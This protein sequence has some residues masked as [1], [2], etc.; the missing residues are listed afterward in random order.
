MVPLSSR[1][2]TLVNSPDDENDEIHL[3][4]FACTTRYNSVPPTVSIFAFLSVYVDYSL[5]EKY[6]SE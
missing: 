1:K 4:S 6:L 3:V 2:L 5:V